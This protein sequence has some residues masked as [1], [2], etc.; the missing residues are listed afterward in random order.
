MKALGGNYAKLGLDGKVKYRKFPIK[1]GKP[2]YDLIHGHFDVRGPTLVEAS[3]KMTTVIPLRHPALIA[4]SWKKRG[5]ARK[6]TPTFLEQWMYMCE[7]TG[8][9]F[10]LETKPFEALADYTNLRV[11]PLDKVVNSIGD[12][13]EKR[14][15]QAIKNFLGRDWALVEA[16]LDTEIGRRFYGPDNLICRIRPTRSGRFYG[17]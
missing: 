15:L 1:K 4:T 14:D 17:F 16:A 9:L 8:F 2:D 12:Y 6:R 7:A 10:P 11:R 3:H 5:P 13:D